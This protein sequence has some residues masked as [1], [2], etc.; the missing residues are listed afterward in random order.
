MRKIVCTVGLLATL[1]AGC[2]QGVDALD[3]IQSEL[4]K[5]KAAQAEQ[6]PAGLGDRSEILGA[7][8]PFGVWLEHSD[9]Q[10]SHH[11]E[12]YYYYQPEQRKEIFDVAAKALESRWVPCGQLRGADGRS[13]WT[14]PNGD[15]TIT[16]E[17]EDGQTSIATVTYSPSG[18]RYCE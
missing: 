14:R 16:L 13:T 3:V 17:F 9:K 15:Q 12:S 8:M 5:T 6:P 1:T 11:S 18:G 4:S 7:H 2:S 10:S